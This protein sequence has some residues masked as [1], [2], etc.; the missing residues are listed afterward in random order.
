M[1]IADR[2][3]GRSIPACAGEPMYAATTSWLQAV[4]PR[5][6]GGTPSGRRR[7]GPGVGL[8]PRVRGNP[9]R[10]VGR[11]SGQWSIPTCAGEPTHALK[12]RT[13]SSVYPRVC[14]GTKGHLIRQDGQTGLS[15]RVR[16]NRH[17]LY[18][19]PDRN[20]SIPACAGEPFTL[21]RNSW[22]KEVYPRVC[23][24][25]IN[26]PAFWSAD[27]GLSPRVRGNRPAFPSASCMPW[28]IPACAGE[29][30]TSCETWCR[31]WVYPR[32][33]GGTLHVVRDLVQNLGLSPRVRGNLSFYQ[34][35]SMPSR[36]IPACA[37]EPRS[38]RLW[39]FVRW[40]YPRVCGGTQDA[41]YRKL[42]ANG[43]SPRVRG[44]RE[45]V[46]LHVD[47][48]RSIPACAG[49]PRLRQCLNRCSRVYPRV[50]GGTVA[51]QSVP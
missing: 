7:A 37:G 8:S 16:G 40:V 29:P 27:M 28:S 30:C 19:S 21:M 43:L 18:V 13:T 38:G 39:P 24:G 33:C 51:A 42:L 46:D 5:V 26:V 9:V 12:M 15:P 49:E 20:G 25:T 45:D 2:S 17:R 36:S 50:C 23:G 34:T 47:K 3:G 10:V 4:Y 31:T 1:R 35:G 11:L 32:V 48:L 6:C 44:N 22:E 14:G 41:T